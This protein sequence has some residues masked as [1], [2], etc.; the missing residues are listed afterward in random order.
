[1]MGTLVPSPVSPRASAR[2]ADDFGIV[3][4]HLPNFKRLRFLVL[5]AADPC[6]ETVLVKKFVYVGST[7]GRRGGSVRE[8]PGQALILRLF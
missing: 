4:V 1:M 5:L 6:P 7:K 3:P 8:D 2:A